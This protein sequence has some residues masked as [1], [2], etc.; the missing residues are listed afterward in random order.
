MQ[1][2]IFPIRLTYSKTGRARYISHLDTM[3]SLTRALRRA[4]LPLWYTQGFN[5]HL[6]L[7]FL[8][9]LALGVESHCEIVDLRLTEEMDFAR[10]TEQIDK[11]LPPGFAVTGVAAPVLPAKAIAWAEYR[12]TLTF[13][14][15]E[16]GGMEE[17]MRALLAQESIPARKK[18]KKGEEVV[19]IRPHCRL[20]ALSADRD[21]L[22]LQIRLAAGVSLNVA[23]K[24]LLEAFAQAARPPERVGILR[25]RV[26]DQGEND[27]L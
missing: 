12:L 5:P 11:H 20:I 21:R 17:A 13:P 18:T 9:P 22:D 7:T 3:R 4:G 23:P 16:G 26:L 6:Y 8:L 25:T 1:E 27:F 2:V 24:T 10:L 14:A 15:G 19:D